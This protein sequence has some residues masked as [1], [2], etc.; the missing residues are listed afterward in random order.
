[1]ALFDHASRLANLRSRMAGEE[2]DVILLSIG[3]DMPWLLGYEAMASERLTMAVV[4]Q[5]GDVRLV[6]PQ[7]E[8]PRVD[9]GDGLFEVVAWSETQD[10]LALV[11]G[12]AGDARSAAIGDHTWAR[13]VIGLQAHAPKLRMQPASRVLAPLRVRKDAAEVALLRETAEAA[14]TVSRALAGERFSGRTEADLARSVGEA[15]VAAGCS[16]A[17]F[18]IVASGPNAASPHHEPGDREMRRGD[19]VV[20]DFGGTVGGY[21]SDTTRTFVVG[22]PTPEVAAAFEVLAQA[23]RT[24]REAA[25]VGAAAGAIDR[26]TR[27]VIDDGG[28]GEHFIHRTGHGIGLEVHEDPYLVE[29]NDTPIQAGMAF[30]IEPGIYMPGKWGM[31]IEDIVVASETG[32]QVLNNTTRSLVVVG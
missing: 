28:Y 23:Q 13:F 26:K 9:T 8:A 21:H 16:R 27:A 29:G 14:D 1:M 30:S 10:P 6:V 32:P 11:A 15:T 7:L 12:F 24:G 25:L 5:E 2:L 20:V 17:A 18:T 22:D 31:R 3:A 4:P 19:T